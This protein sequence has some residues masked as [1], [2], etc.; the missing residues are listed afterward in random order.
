MDHNYNNLLVDYYGNLLTD[1]QLDILK[2][3]FYEDLSMNEIAENRKVSKAAISDIIKRSL[4][5]LEE[6]ESK[7]HLIKDT[8]KIN[9]V[10]DTMDKTNNKD[11]IKY[12]KSIRKI[13]RG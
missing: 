1:H 9:N 5:Q 13:L 12:S 6:Y 4:K 3:Y 8:D 11:I 10:L 7:L 2:D